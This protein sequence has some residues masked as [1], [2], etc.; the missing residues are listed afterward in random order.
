VVGSGSSCPHDFRFLTAFDSD[1]DSDMHDVDAGVLEA[2]MSLG[3]MKDGL[4]KSPG[5]TNFG[6]CEAGSMLRL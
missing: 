6:P 5:L 4:F 1:L 3:E 2:E